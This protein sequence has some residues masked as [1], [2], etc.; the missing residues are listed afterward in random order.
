MNDSAPRP[1]ERAAANAARGWRFIA[2]LALLLFLPVLG[3][4]AVAEEQKP[5]D[6]PAPT[7]EEGTPPPVNVAIH[8]LGK[9]Y[10][11]PPP[12]SLVDP[13]LTDNGAARADADCHPASPFDNGTA[14]ALAPAG[15][16]RRFQPA[17]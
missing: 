7:A 2:A 13:V 9:N 8:Y 5:A 12:L 17:P 14:S 11:E 15:M 1:I 4:G 16:S 3:L 10:D 6:T